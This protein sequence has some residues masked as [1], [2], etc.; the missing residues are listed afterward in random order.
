MQFAFQVSVTEDDK[1]MSDRGR[2]Y[3]AAV[4][5]T[6]APGEMQSVLGRTA[7][8]YFATLVNGIS[9]IGGRLERLYLRS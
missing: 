9:R 6:P 4:S 2:V 8:A 3:G 1:D 5:E 7:Q